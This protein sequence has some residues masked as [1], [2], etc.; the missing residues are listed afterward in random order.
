MIEYL[1]WLA[2]GVF[3]A[4]YFCKAPRATRH[5]QMVGALLWLAYGTLIS[6]APV[7]VANALV[8]GAAALTTLRT[9]TS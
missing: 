9:R 6:A 7:V 2:T 1:G 8:F 5:V 3:V 4:S